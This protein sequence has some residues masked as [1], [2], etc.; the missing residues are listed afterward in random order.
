MY[1]DIVISS[2]CNLNK[3]F[4]S[5]IFLFFFLPLGYRVLKLC[6]WNFGVLDDNSD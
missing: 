6:V 2:V 5:F 3:H 1:V 4:F